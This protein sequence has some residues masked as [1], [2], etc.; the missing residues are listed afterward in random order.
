MTRMT[1]WQKKYFHLCNSI[2]NHPNPLKME[3]L[4]EFRMDTI[5]IKKYSEEFAAQAGDKS[6]Y[7]NMYNKYLISFYAD[8]EC[9]AKAVVIAE[10]ELKNRSTPQTNAWYAWLF[11]K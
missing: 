10:Q 11:F 9:P 3:Q 8:S 4:A 1:H 5:A 7:G 2:P 6:L